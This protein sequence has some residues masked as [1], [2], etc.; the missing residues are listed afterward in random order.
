MFDKVPIYTLNHLNREDDRSTVED[1]FAYFID[2][3]LWIIQVQDGRNYMTVR[4]VG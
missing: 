1:V 2:V 3:H 4:K